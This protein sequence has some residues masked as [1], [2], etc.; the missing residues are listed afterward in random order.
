MKTQGKQENNGKNKEHN[1][2]K[3][4]NKQWNM[5]KTK[6]TQVTATGPGGEAGSMISKMS[7]IGY[8]D[9]VIQIHTRTFSGP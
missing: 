4:R 5:E 9:T 2:Q 8:G 7:Q 1:K 3:A 6:K